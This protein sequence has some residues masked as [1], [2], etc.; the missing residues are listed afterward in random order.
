LQTWLPLPD[1]GQS[2]ACL[3][4]K[5]LGKQR[6][7]CKQ[8]LNAL[9]GHK[10]G[11]KHHPVTKMWAGHEGMLCVYAIIMT[12]EW[13]YR[14]YEDSMLDWFFE[15]GASLPQESFTMPPFIGDASFHIHHQSRLCWKNPEFYGAYGWCGF[16]IVLG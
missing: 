7:E 13:R 2:A 9:I 10:Q 15:L 8:I 12:E 6:V 4:Y 3:D 16:R 1:F 14:G 5:R 11:W